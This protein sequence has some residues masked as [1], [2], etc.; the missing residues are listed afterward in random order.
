MKKKENLAEVVN[1]AAD[2]AEPTPEQIHES[3][4]QVTELVKQ[5]L[6]DDAVMIQSFKRQFVAYENTIKSLKAKIASLEKQLNG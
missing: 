4:V 6:F 1:Q 5:Q 3:N 2:A